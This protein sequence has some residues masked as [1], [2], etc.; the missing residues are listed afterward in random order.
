MQARI[1]DKGK[2]EALRFDLDA[3]RNNMERAIAI[4]TPLFVK[5]QEAAS[6]DEEAIG[7]ALDVLT[8]W[9]GQN[10]KPLRKLDELEAAVHW[11][12][13]QRGIQAKENERLRAALDKHHR[14]G[15]LGYI[16]SRPCP[17]CQEPLTDAEVERLAKFQ[18]NSIDRPT[19]MFQFS[20]SGR[21]ILEL[22]NKGNESAYVEISNRPA[23]MPKPV[24]S[25]RT[26]MMIG[27]FPIPI[28]GEHV[29]VTYTPSTYVFP[30][31]I[32][33]E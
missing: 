17:V 9:F 21:T 18:V 29:M 19:G 16:H 31:I 5:A 2:I 23:D 26:A 12:E 8:G 27:P 10:G 32:E 1:A 25:P 30:R 7:S 11:N 14:I 28:F 6:S 3:A 22:A 33:N 20:N 4:L 15:D 24:I 13:Q